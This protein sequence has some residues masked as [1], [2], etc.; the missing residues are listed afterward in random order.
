MAKK[1]RLIGGK[2]YGRSKDGSEVAYKKGDI[3]ELTDAQA[4]AF[5]DK[6]QEVIESE[7]TS[8]GTPV[9]PATQAAPTPAT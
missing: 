7:A 8:K 9:K 5:G 1:Y 6:F 4:K 3:V 2:H